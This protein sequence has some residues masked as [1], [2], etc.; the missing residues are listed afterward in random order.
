M[1][2]KHNMQG[3]TLPELLLV[4]TIIALL[5][6][7]A[8]PSYMNFVR[9]TRLENAR[10]DLMENAKRLEH[11]YSQNHTFNGFNRLKNDNLFFD[12]AIARSDGTG[13]M[14][15]GTPNNANSGEQRVIRLNSDGVTTICTDSSQSN[16]TM[17]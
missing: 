13:Y 9:K 3:F 1:K 2:N 16:C 14:I 6:A 12:I 4:I 15:V 8:Y 17:Y 5:A 10:G 7:I 11:F